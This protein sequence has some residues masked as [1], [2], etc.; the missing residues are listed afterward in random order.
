M[1]TV[2][3]TRPQPEALQWQRLLGDAGLSTTVLPL[4]DIAPLHDSATQAALAAARAELAQYRAVMFVSSNAVRHFLAA[5]GMQ[6]AMLL[7]TVSGT[8]AWAP[9]PGTRQVLLQA[10]VSADQVDSPAPD[11]GQFDSE[12]LWAVVGPQIR[13]GDRVLIVRGASSQAPAGLQGSGREW[14]AQCL[15]TQGAQVDLL[16]VYAR[17]CP[18]AT[19]A[20]TSAIAASCQAASLWLFSSSE[21]IAHLCQIM[22]QQSWGSQHALTTHPRIAAAARAAGFG[23]VQECKPD[24]VD[25]RASIESWP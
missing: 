12:S 4:I 22:P 23:Q 17:Q 20:L 7:A 18:A 14:L 10:G 11:A 2:V 16:G 19:A 5:P 3:L 25:V 9:G 15:R 6:A 21:A 1:R 24:V 8:R 13:P